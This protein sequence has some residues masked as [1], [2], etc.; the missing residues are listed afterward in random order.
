MKQQPICQQGLQSSDGLPG[1]REFTSKMAYSCGFWQIASV[2]LLIA[3]ASP[4]QRAVWFPLKQ[5]I[6]DREAETTMAFMSLLSQAQKWHTIIQIMWPTDC[7]HIKPRYSVRGNY[8]R[9]CT[10]G[11]GSHCMLFWSLPTTELCLDHDSNKLKKIFVVI[12]N[13]NA[14]WI[15]Y[16]IMELKRIWYVL[17]VFLKTFYLL[18][19][20]I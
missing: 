17:V 7:S 2:L 4:H 18:E 10:P 5:V 15:S 14:Y 6:Q 3:C 13:L 8:A 19:I 12:R 11:N 20:H 16:D 1:A 9:V